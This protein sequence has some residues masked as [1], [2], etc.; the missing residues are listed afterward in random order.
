MSIL[1]NQPLSV[2]GARLN[3][4][5]GYSKMGEMGTFSLL[6]HILPLPPGEGWGEGIE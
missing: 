1:I 2:S 6:S 3:V 4:K 5:N